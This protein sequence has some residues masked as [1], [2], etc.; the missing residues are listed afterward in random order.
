MPGFLCLDSLTGLC[1][2]HTGEPVFFRPLQQE[3][4]DVP[5]RVGRAVGL[6]L[7]WGEADR[8]RT[9]HLQLGCSRSEGWWFSGSELIR[10]HLAP[11][12]P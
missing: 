12:Q 11:G 4:P 3:S 2:H 10:K 7:F 1:K 5:V 6:A 9:H 8:L